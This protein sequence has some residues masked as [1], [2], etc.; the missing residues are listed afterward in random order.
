MMEDLAQLKKLYLKAKRAYYNSGTT[1]M[2]DEE[3]DLLEDKIR[4][5]DPSWSELNKTGIKVGKKEEVKL[6]YF[7]PSLNK[8]YPEQVDKLW[9]KF[10]KE[11]VKSFVFMPKLD[12]CSVLIRY[13]KGQPK[14]LITR[15]NGILGKDISFLLPY[16]NV[17]VIK[18]ERFD[19]CIRCEAILTRQAYK[20]WE[21]EFDNARNMVSGLLNR[22][23]PHKA[24]QDIDFVALGI[25]GKPLGKSLNFLAKHYKY[26]VDY[27]ITQD[28]PEDIYLRL[29]AKWKS[30]SYLY[31]AD[32]IVIADA[33]FSYQYDN[34][35]KPKH[36]IFA[37]KIN[38]D[39]NAV[40][41]KVESI[42]WQTSGFGRLVP[43]IQIEPTMIQ[44]AKVT[45]ATAHNAQWM[46]DRKIGP[47]AVVKL[48]RSGDVIPKIIDVLKPADFMQLPAVAYKQD[49]V[50]FVAVQESDEQLINA[51]TRA[52][53]IME[54][55]G[56][57][58]G[59]VTYL[60]EDVG[61]ATLNQLISMLYDEA[62]SAYMLDRLTEDLGPV[63]GKKLYDSLMQLIEKPYS[64][65]DWMLSSGTFDSG[66][67]RKRLEE[68]AKF[69]DLNHYDRA[70]ASQVQGFGDQ[71]LPM[72][73]SSFA[74][75]E[76]WKQKYC[77][78]IQPFAP[79]IQEEKVEGILSG[80]HFTFTGYRSQEQ[81]ATLKAL[82]G[83]VISFSKKTDILLYKKDG[84]AST[85]I[86]KAG[87]KAMTWEE[88]TQK[89]PQLQSE[90]KEHTKTL[91]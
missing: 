30:P 21:Q 69:M 23:E 2:S 60:Y 48:V 63:R 41:A 59:S 38:A 46:V 82:G 49:G 47:G 70:I 25:F 37:F 12:G 71:L 7:M 73:D 26:S 33:E 34:A 36:S 66:I 32:G 62:D 44:G 14:Q 29:F 8:F 39:T 74:Q 72:L 80:L 20:K 27:L 22:Q 5:L 85:K 17:P 55:D 1:I 87:D 45:Y 78:M 18:D 84:K 64:I 57:K 75:F 52:L 16:L 79:L 6:P 54:I 77:P 11:E 42:V 81:E 9:Q 76:E 51:L 91:F 53:S 28:K 13:E 3:Y 31:E 65:I 40:E 43:K 89:Y 61:I 83:E 10:A 88:L 24:M 50:H 56:A 19:Y 15:G 86:A 67:G 90:L 58:K 68:L 35:D 4:S